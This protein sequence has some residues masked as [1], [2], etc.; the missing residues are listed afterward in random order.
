MFHDTRN[1]LLNHEA[2]AAWCGSA[3]VDG[4]R[5][6]ELL[7]HRQAFEF[8]LVLEWAGHFRRRGRVFEVALK[9]HFVPARVGMPDG[10]LPVSLRFHPLAAR[11]YQS[12][13]ADVLSEFLS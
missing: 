6:I 2:G 13:I 4:Q 11:A 5:L 9:R 1:G 3:A 12:Y 7:R 8:Q 10:F